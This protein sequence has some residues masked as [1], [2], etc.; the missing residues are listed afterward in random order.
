M[1]E[2]SAMQVLLLC[3]HVVSHLVLAS[4]TPQATTAQQCPALEVTW[5]LGEAPS[6]GMVTLTCTACSHFSH[7][8]I[9]YW[10]GNGSFIEHLPGPLHE[11]S[12]SRAHSS[13]HTQLRNSLV[14]EQLNPA[15]CSTNFTCVFADPAII[16]QHHVILSQSGVPPCHPEASSSSHSLEPQSPT[17]PGV[18]TG[19]TPLP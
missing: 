15:L 10:L 4:A 1:P 2:P 9:L 14:L 13:T 3:A 16:A 19:T 17:V 12:T 6:N 18:S 11:G 7:F 5:S 8:S